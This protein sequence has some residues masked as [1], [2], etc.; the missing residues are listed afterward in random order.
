MDLT[1]LFN[2]SL[3]AAGCR[4]TVSIHTERSREAE[5]CN[6][7]YESVRDQVLRAAFWSS[8]KGA[9]RLSVVVERDVD[10]AWATT[11]PD[12]GWRYSY[13]TPNDMLVPRFLTDFTRFE[14][15]NAPDNS[16]RIISQTE[17]AVLIYTKKQTE[18]DAWDVDLRMAIIYA[19][20]SHICLPLQGKLDRVQLSVER[21]NA[22]ITNA[23]VNDANIN[24]NQYES[25]PEWYTARGFVGT[26]VPSRYYYPYGPI[27]AVTEGVDIR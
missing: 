8:A 15:T 22:L 7:W 19:L 10:V 11:D 13:S 25:M 21:A 5:T 4:Q 12:P 16:S 17:Q 24:E 23:R 18:I 9:A 6:R 26:T 3:D 27:L 20:A 2:L 14:L 1:A